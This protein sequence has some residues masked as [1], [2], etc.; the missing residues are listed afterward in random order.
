MK[1]ENL[2]ERDQF[3]MLLFNLLR[4]KG[5][6]NKDF[7]DNSE[8]CAICRTKDS[9]HDKSCIVFKIKLALDLY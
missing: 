5:L 9:V 4:N 2:E 7:T 8:Y 1:I 6:Y 3:S